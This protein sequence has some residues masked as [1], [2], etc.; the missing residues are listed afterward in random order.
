MYIFFVFSFYTI[1]HLNFF[2]PISNS[3]HCTYVYPSFPLLFTHCISL[4]L[5][6]SIHSLYISSFS[7]LS[8]ILFLRKYIIYPFLFYFLLLS[9]FY[10]FIPF[11]LYFFI[12]F[13]TVPYS[14]TSSASH[15]RTDRQA[16][17]HSGSV[18]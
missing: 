1:S 2:L 18:V 5:L 17:T 14:W 16:D 10:S 4:P 9:F 8:H 11:L 7:T 13:L 3:S 15:V 12:P 6:L